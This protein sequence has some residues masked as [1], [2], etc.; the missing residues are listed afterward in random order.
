MQ[1]LGVSNEL[2][3]KAI[4]KKEFHKKKDITRFVKS[5]L[6]SARNGKLELEVLQKQESFRIRSFIHSNIWAVFPSGKSDFKKGD[7]IDCYIPH[8]SNK[9]IN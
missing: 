3:L 1:I 8:L 7:I 4:L 2:P 6:T 9:N 5:K